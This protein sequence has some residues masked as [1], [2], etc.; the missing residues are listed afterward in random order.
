MRARR[1]LQENTPMQVRRSV[2]SALQERTRVLLVQ[3][4][5]MY[6]HLAAQANFLSK[7]QQSVLINA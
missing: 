3:Q 2:Q 6:V 4:V 5:L 1:V 7:L